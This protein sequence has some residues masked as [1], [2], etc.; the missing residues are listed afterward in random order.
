[1]LQKR[2]KAGKKISYMLLCHVTEYDAI[3]EK[4][5]ACH[6]VHIHTV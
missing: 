5:G 1:M 3:Q 6:P 4:A 2:A